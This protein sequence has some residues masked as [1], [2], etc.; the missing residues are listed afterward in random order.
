MPRK[1]NGFVPTGA[2][3]AGVELPDSRAMTPA[4]P[5][6]LHH[7]TRLDQIDQLVEA[8][9]TD[10]AGP[11]AGCSFSFGEQEKEDSRVHTTVGAVSFRF[12]GSNSF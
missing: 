11:L 12:H 1:R 10:A 4:A 7:F 8:R 3:V 6:A 9:E 2:V 5:Q